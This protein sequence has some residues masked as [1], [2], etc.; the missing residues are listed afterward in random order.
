MEYIRWKVTVRDA[1]DGILYW[2]K[3]PP[4]HELVAA[5]FSSREAGPVAAP[6][7]RKSSAPPKSTATFA[8]LEGFGMRVNPNPVKPMQ[9]N[10]LRFDTVRKTA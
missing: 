4:V 2:S 3:N 5:V 6:S 9:L 7:S 1:M 8:G 10:P